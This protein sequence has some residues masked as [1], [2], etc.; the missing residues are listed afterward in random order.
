MTLPGGEPAV[1]ALADQISQVAAKQEDQAARTN[2]G[3]AELARASTA[4]IERV[5]TGD[6]SPNRPG[7]REER[8]AATPASAQNA[9]QRKVDQNASTA[10][11]K[12]ALDAT[13]YKFRT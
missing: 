13:G 11:E 3:I 8:L 1:S 10:R 4:L 6:L 2:D 7:T 12:I 9:R 5:I